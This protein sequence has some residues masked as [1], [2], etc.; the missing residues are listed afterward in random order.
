MNCA[1]CNKEFKYLCHLTR[2]QNATRKCKQN[3][4]LVENIFTDDLKTL[5]TKF[6]KI[7]NEINTNDETFENNTCAYCFIVYSSKS[8]LVNHIKK[9]CKIRRKLE[10]QLKNIENLINSFNVQIIFTKSTVKPTPP[11]IPIPQNPNLNTNLALDPQYKRRSIPKKIRELVWD[12]YIG[13]QIGETK[14][15]CC[16]QTNISQLSFHCG[17]IISDYNGGDTTLRNLLPICISCNLSMGTTNLY[18]FKKTFG[19]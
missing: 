19:L 1:N 6:K 18:D 11:I 17:H 10:D 15:K 2:H 14:C 8:N 12:S 9:S 13:R 3:L 7:K 16:E 4:N 5:K